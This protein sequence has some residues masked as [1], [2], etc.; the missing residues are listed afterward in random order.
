MSITIKNS[1]AIN[2]GG[3]YIQSDDVTID[4]LHVQHG[5]GETWLH[6]DANKKR[7]ET[8]TKTTNSK[9]YFAGWTPPKK[10][11]KQKITDILS[12]IKFLAWIIALFTG[13]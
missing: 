10:S 5:R 13:K 12:N 1:S 9:T 11:I 4:N 3:A 2:C 7:T 6:V 8:A